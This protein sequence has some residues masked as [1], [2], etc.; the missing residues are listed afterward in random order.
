MPRVTLLFVLGVVSTSTFLS[1]QQPSLAGDWLG[2]LQ[3]GPTELR[4]VFHVTGEAG[5]YAATLDSP[6]QGVAGIPVAA[7]R[8]DGATV[9]M[10]IPSLRGRYEGT[11]AGDGTRLEGTWSQGGAVLPLVLSHTTE[12]IA[13]PHRPQEPVEPVP[14]RSQD[15]RLPGGSPEVTLAGT[16]T[17]PEGNGPFPAVVLISGS[18][19]QNRNEELMGHRPFL[20][21][22]D[23]FTRRG[24]AV[25]RYDDRGVGESTGAFGT[26]TSLDFA[27]DALAAVRYLS[28]RT[29]IDA[30]RIGLVGHSEG[31]LIAPIVAADHDSVAFVVMMAGPGIPGSEILELQ[32]GLIL[33]AGGASS[34]D[35]RRAVEA[36]RELNELIAAS[37]DGQGLEERVRQRLEQRAAALSESER[38]AAGVTPESLRAQAAQV[39]SPWFR[40]FLA[41]DPVPTLRRVQVPVLAINGSK[42]LQVPPRENLEA[43]GRALAAGGNADVSTEELPGLNHLFQT[44]GTGAP[45]EYAQIEETIAPVAL[46]RMTRWILDRFGS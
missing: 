22:A 16:L 25:L 7:V 15:V 29:E 17:L 44:A 18:G 31:G 14:Y 34:A 32:T 27:D 13:L 11:L 2:T 35:V 8:V 4:I 41:Y 19:P 37:R 23:H 39:T 43:I 38:Q 24:I 10:D 5:G 6:D 3:A 46:D 30:A 33:K 12:P 42:D 45:S 26:A 40:F 28:S 9:S 20:V 36:T 1:A 21:L